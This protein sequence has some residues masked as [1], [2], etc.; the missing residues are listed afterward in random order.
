MDLVVGA[1][2]DAVKSLVSKLGSLLAQEYTLIRGVSDDIQ[3]I[4]DELASMHAFLNRLKQEAKHDEQR[5]DWMK[6]VREVAYDIEDCVD[7]VRHRLG[8]EP[9]GS[10]RA[11]LPQAEMVPAHH[12]VRAP[13]H[14]HRSRSATSR[15]GHSTSA[16]GAPGTGWRT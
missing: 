11:G 7:K 10:G 6:Q 12:A 15:P 9:R 4:N 16:S 2:N 3:Y 13:L 14:R 1:S 5:Q 8:R